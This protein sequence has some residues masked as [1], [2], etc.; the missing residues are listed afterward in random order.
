MSLNNRRSSCRK[1][2]S[3]LATQA[4]KV[5]RRLCEVGLIELLK[6]S[7]YIEELIEDYVKII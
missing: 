7:K 3:A 2:S 5:H 6:D 1:I 4:F